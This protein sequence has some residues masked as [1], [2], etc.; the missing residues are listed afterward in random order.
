VVFVFLVN[1]RVTKQACIREKWYNCKGTQTSSDS[2]GVKKGDGCFLKGH[3]LTA[4]VGTRG[5]LSSNKNFNGKLSL[6]SALRK[7]MPIPAG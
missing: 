7:D 6:K 5:I 1:L 2:K 3:F 4:C